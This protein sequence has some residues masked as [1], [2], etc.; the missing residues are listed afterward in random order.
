MDGTTGCTSA[1]KFKFSCAE[2]L[3][4]PEPDVPSRSGIESFSL[5]VRTPDH[6]VSGTGLLGTPLAL[7]TVTRPDEPFPPGGSVAVTTVRDQLVTV[8]GVVPDASTI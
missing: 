4:F 1:R 2:I 3:P 7:R 8:N 6:W 5:N